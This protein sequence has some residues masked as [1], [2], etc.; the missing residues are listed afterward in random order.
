[1]NKLEA[2]QILSEQLNNL[3]KLSYEELCKFIGKEYIKLLEIVG[4]SG[5]KYQIEIKVFWDDKPGRDVRV[6]G[7]IDDGGWRAFFP[8]TDS[9]IVAPSGEFVGE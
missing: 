1:M 7:A 6:A 4:N 3:R 5:I 2:K 8:M 9:F